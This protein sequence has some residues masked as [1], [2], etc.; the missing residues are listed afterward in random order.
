MRK[1]FKEMKLT[2]AVAILF[3]A[4][5]CAASGGG[6]VLWWLVG[7]NYE[8]ITVT[9]VGGAVKTAGE[10]GVSDVRVRYETESG[11]SGYLTLFGVNDDGSVSV[12]DGSV[13]LGGAHG[14]GLPAEYFG[15]LSGLSGTSC[16]FVLELGNWA[17]GA[18]TKTLFESE[19]VSYQQ[20]LDAGHISKWEGTTPVYGTP[21]QPGTYVIPEP[22]SGLLFLV[23]GAFLLL[24]RRRCVR[25]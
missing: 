10:L 1:A 12:Y 24:R 2:L 16:S 25:G 19:R 17:N 7:D 20:L 4:G 22:T 8:S 23:G 3:C 18:W 21:W 13:S 5:T 15:D 11:G 9:T 6:E 14:V